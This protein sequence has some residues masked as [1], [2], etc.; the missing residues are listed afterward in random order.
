MALSL[1]RDVGESFFIGTD[2]KITIRRAAKG[3]CRIAIDAPDTVIIK[4]EELLPEA[5]QSNPA[6]LRERAKMA[7]NG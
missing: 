7:A 2:T 1:S 4:R 5:E 3:R 6:T